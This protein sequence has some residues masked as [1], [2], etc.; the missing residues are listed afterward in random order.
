M[1]AKGDFA[2]FMLKEIFEQPQALQNVL[3]GRIQGDRVVW[4]NFQVSREQINQWNKI[5]IIACGSAYHSGLF[6]KLLLEKFLGMMV[7]VEIASEFR[8]R[9]SLVDENTLAIF[10]SQSG[11]TAD[12]LAA[13]R[14]AKKKKAFT[15]ALTNVEKSTISREAD[16]CLSLK[17]GPEIAV[18]STKAYTA[19]LVMQYLL[20]IYFAQ[21]KKTL[22]AGERARIL[23]GLLELPRKTSLILE[24]QEPYVQIAKEL[25]SAENL[26][27]L[28]RL[29][30]YYLA[31][32]GALKL[33]ETAYLH[34]EAYASGEI[35][36][37][38]LAIVTPNTPIVAI[39]VQ[40]SVYKPTLAIVKEVVQQG[41]SVIG[42]V[43]EGD[44]EMKKWAR[45]LLTIPRIDNL[46]SP[47]LAVIPLQLLAY[48]TAVAKGCAIDQ[49]RNLT[50]AVTNDL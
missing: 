28:G 24:E 4:E 49:P 8:Y 2:H 6:G 9:D 48:Y 50:K 37:G 18:A 45:H 30:D 20:S 22:A 1:N 31:R 32:E 46:V 10:I 7:E 26:F 39:A 33:K 19:M 36:H 15:L 3:E 34:A 17:V 42:V 23:K 47:I 27:Y 41:A 25:K 13:L 44:Q 21:V 11:E 43:N 35:R 16:V 38:T 14:L 12:T 40:E 5:Y 29:F